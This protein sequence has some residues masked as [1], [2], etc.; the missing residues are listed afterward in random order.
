MLHR[1]Y[2]DELGRL[3][4]LAGEFARDNPALAPML[5]GSSADPDVERLL[6]GVAFLT[7]LL[8]DKL[9]DAF[10]EFIQDLTTLV[11][12][13]YLMAMPCSAM[14]CFRPRVDEGR[15][16]TIPRGTE[17]LSVPV[18]GT[19]CRFR[20]CHDLEV[21]GLEI[22]EASLQRSPGQAPALRL[23]L[24][25]ADGTRPVQLSGLRLFL[26]GSHAEACHLLLLLTR[27]VRAVHVGC[28]KPSGDFEALHVLP[29]ETL[30]PAGFEH[31]LLDYPA[32]AFDGYRVLQEYFA[33]PAKFLF[34][35]LDGVPPLPSGTREVRLDLQLDRAWPW[36]PEVR[37]DSFMLGVVPAVNLFEQDAEPIE[38]DHRRSEYPLV[39]QVPTPEHY[40]VHE[41]EQ[42]VGLEHGR[43]QTRTWQ[44]F[45]LYP[46]P[47]AQRVPGYRSVVRPHPL[48]ATPHTVL[49]LNY[50]PGH[51][52]R[53][54]VLS[55]RLRCT[56]GSLPENLGRGDICH[57]TTTTPD[58]TRFYNLQP[59]SPARSA[60]ADAQSM[61]RAQSHAA[62]NFLSLADAATLRSMLG[63]YASGHERGDGPEG[64]AL[65]AANQRRIE[66]IETV[67]AE[68]QTVIVGPCSML[69]GQLVR[70]GCRP[71][72]FAGV[73]DLYLFGCVLDAFFADYA[74]INSFVQLEIE[75]LQTSSV[76]T[77][78]PRTGTRATL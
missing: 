35:R 9:D 57:A 74:G 1:H 17:V 29:A 39:P 4:T 53:P 60:R 6:E 72:H 48:D 58:R 45:H 28:L 3:K 41:I 75:N 32:H 11:L 34:V 51:V 50:P 54:E 65:E 10:P 27:H 12:P 59:P 71:E 47:D 8:R 23:R 44:P 67:H 77:W 25:V 31:A 46:G 18:D 78:P 13:H 40:R 20:T 37:N 7:A 16:L 49:S 68:P 64:A 69:R 2:E 66:G 70:V 55:V 62:L 42:V 19:A 52:P 26:D 56:N 15:A 76:Y 33:Q 36:M 73:G 38:V 30:R 22:A 24:R 14:M 5:L 43:Q 21:P 61:W 63:L